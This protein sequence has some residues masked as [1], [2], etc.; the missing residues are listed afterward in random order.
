MVPWRHCELTI[1]TTR[2]SI[3]SSHTNTLPLTTYFPSLDWTID[4]Y[5][6]IPQLKKKHKQYLILVR[7]KKCILLSDKKQYSF[8]YLL[9]SNVNEIKQKYEALIFILP[10]SFLLYSCLF[11][12]AWRIKRLKGHHN[13]PPDWNRLDRLIKN[14][15]CLSRD[16]GSNPRAWSKVISDLRALSSI[17]VLAERV[18]AV[19]CLWHA[20]RK[21]NCK[22]LIKIK[23]EKT[24]STT[25][26]YYYIHTL[27]EKIFRRKIPRVS[28]L[29]RRRNT[30]QPKVSNTLLTT[31][32][33]PL[34]VCTKRSL[35]AANTD[36]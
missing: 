6:N 12:E 36:H 11:I 20:K 23:N 30:K 35:E 33:L 4:Y 26:N 19:C 16:L 29:P 8:P 17:Q 31:V 3:S 10:S 2:C 24:Y 5:P 15:V 34:T 7:T 28:S 21:P 1:I 22:S 25:S 32:Q 14:D 9:W 13:T 27:V 18:L